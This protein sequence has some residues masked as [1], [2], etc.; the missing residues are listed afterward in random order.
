MLVT[1]TRVVHLYKKCI[2]LGAGALSGSSIQHAPVLHLEKVACHD[3][4]AIRESPAGIFIRLLFGSACFPVFGPVGDGFCVV[5]LPCYAPGSVDESCISL[6][7]STNK[8]FFGTPRSTFGI[9]GLL[10]C[11]SVR[12]SGREG[13]AERRASDHG[14]AC[15]SRW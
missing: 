11:F 3:A 5:L 1:A 8:P 10:Y 6:A 15:S 2:D 4:G 12:A 13:A 14:R 9:P 7:P